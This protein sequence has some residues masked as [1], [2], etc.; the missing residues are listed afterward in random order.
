MYYDGNEIWA[1]NVDG[2]AHDGYHQAKIDPSI[3]PYLTKKGFPIPANNIIEFYQK[4][5]GSVVLFEGMDHEAI[6]DI[7]LNVAETVRKAEA[8]TIIEANVDTYQVKCHTKVVGKYPHFNKLRDIP[9]SDVLKIKM[10]LI[11]ILKTI[12]PYCHDRIDILDSKVATPRKL[13]VAWKS[14]TE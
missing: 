1:M 9:Q 12:G 7:A 14:I 11:E 10:L 6:N 13:Y 3:N 2:T 4:P 8:I 5:Q